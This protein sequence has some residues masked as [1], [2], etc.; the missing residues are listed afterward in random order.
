ML[1]A[2]IHGLYI[3]EARNSEDY[4]TSAVFGHLR[5]L[6]SSQFWDRLF[7]A[8]VSLPIDGQSLTAAQFIR[9]KAGSSL[10]SFETMHAIFWPKHKKDIPDL[11]L[12][13]SSNVAPSVVILI[14]AKLNATKS[15]IGDYDQLARYLR[16]LDSLDKLKPK[17]PSDAITLAVYL[18]TK[19]SRDELIDSVQKYGD[20]D[21]SRRRLY[22]LQWQDLVD[23]IDATPPSS[24]L[25]RLVLSDVRQFL[26]VRGLEYFS[27]MD[28][29]SIPVI[30]EGDGDFLSEEPLF[31]TESIPIMPHIPYERWMYAH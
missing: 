1:V 23:A 28:W 8:A 21:E 16:V 20:S 2:E 15:G 7:Q 30:Q 18:T 26:R 27:G 5:Y 4:L 24:S 10:A 17:L 25:Q 12:H 22:R 3:P 29:S 31:D 6:Q 13:F 11:I 14:E 19:D 9:A